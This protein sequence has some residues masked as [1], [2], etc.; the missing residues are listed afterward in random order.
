M[1][2]VCGQCQKALLP[3]PPHMYCFTAAVGIL[4]LVSFLSGYPHML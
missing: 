1:T 4:H 3:R 2:A